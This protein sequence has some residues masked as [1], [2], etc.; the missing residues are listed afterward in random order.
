MRV[1]TSDVIVIGGG[2]AGL[3]AAGALGRSGIRVI[4]LEARGRLGGRV[5]TAR[6]KGWDAPVELGPEFV[7]SGNEAFWRF[8]RRHRIG[9]RAVP[10][11]HWLFREEQ[12][13]K[14]DDLAERIGS[15][16]HKIEPK[17]M[18]GWSF[19]DFMRGKA[20]DLARRSGIWRRVSSKVSKL[21]RRSE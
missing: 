13:T 21:R 20:H 17:R 10:P 14:I 2:V 11:R 16:T 3:A 18:R 15:V 19:A 5:F 1:Q 8:L 7:H 6:P 4:L 9:T 12:L